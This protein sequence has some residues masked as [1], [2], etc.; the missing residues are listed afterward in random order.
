MPVVSLL[1]VG[2]LALGPWSH[3]G[4][5]VSTQ[6]SPSM[7]FGHVEVVKLPG[8]E[9]ELRFAWIEPGSFE[10]GTRGSKLKQ[11][12]HRVRLTRG[13]WMQ[14]TE[15]TQATW[16][17]IMGNNPSKFEGPDRP[18]ERVSWQDVQAFLA[19]LNQL[20]IGKFRLPTEA[21]WE[22][23]CRA[24]SSGEYSGD[25]DQMAWYLSNAGGETHPVAQKRPNAWGLYDM[26]GNVF[27]WCQDW[28]QADYYV[29]SPGIDPPGPKQGRFRVY[30]G[31]SWRFPAPLCRSAQ[32]RSGNPVATRTSLLGFRLV[33]SQ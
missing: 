31:G 20:G 17:A 12:A 3:A 5:A 33:R 4:S 24:G 18:V 10:M 8:S 1:W 7:S 19:K 6:A 25:L 15:V 28:F 29:F 11:Q 2:I 32:R 23:A 9:V 21:E 30:R 16:T 13:F 27:E 14:T 22:Y 26:H